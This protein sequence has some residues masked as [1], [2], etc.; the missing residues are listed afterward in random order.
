VNYALPYPP[1]GQAHEWWQRLNNALGTAS[2]AFVEVSLHQLVAAAR[3]P[4]SFPGGFI[5]CNRWAADRF[6]RFGVISESQGQTGRRACW[7]SISG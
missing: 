2:S 7:N 4:Y 5:P 3:L 6:S 1:D